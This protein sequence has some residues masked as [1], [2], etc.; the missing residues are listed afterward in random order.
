MGNTYI[1]TREDMVREYRGEKRRRAERTAKGHFQL[2]LC[3]AALLFLAFF[4]AK[5]LDFSYQGIGNEAVVG[6][7][8]ENEDLSFWQGKIVSVFKNWNSK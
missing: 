6:E 5:E 3:V 2:R 1:R 7:I 8:M 4:A